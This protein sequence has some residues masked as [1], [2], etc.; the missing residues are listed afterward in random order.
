MKRRKDEVEGE[1]VGEEMSWEEEITPDVQLFSELIKDDD[2]T[3]VVQKHKHLIPLNSHKID[4][5]RIPSNL[6]NY[7]MIQ[8]RLQVLID[9]ICNPTINDEHVKFLES[10]N[11]YTSIRMHSAAD[12]WLMKVLRFGPALLRGR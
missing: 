10:Y 1:E 4:F 5:G 9:E 2:V 7:Y 8:A 6:V 3:E 11:I 12:G